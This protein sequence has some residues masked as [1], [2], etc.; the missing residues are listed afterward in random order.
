MS[1]HNLSG[2]WSEQGRDF[3]R[4]P[5]AEISELWANERGADQHSSVVINRPG[6]P[7][8]KRCFSVVCL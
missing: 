6:F 5:L 7:R 8:D 1:H 3:P 2:L 4:E